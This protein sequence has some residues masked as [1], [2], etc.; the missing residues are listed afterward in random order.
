MGREF[1]TL[2]R[3]WRAFAPA[4]RAHVFCDDHAV[5]GSDFLVIEYR[6]GVVIWDSVPVSMAQHA[7]VAHRTGLAVV[8]ALA[9]L[10]RVDPAS[11]DL[12]DLGRPEGFV[13]R[14]VRGWSKRWELASL[15]DAEPVMVEVGEHL[16]GTLPTSRYVSI[17]HNDYKL[18]NCQ[19]DPTD[20][21]HVKSVFDWD[22][23]TLGDPF[24][25]LGITLNYWPDP[26]DPE[27]LRPI[28][29]PGLEHLGLPTRSEV[30][31]RYVER[32]GFDVDDVRWYEAFAAWK[33]AVVLQQ[34]Y[35]RWVRGESTDPRMAERGP[36][37]GKQAR[38]AA[39]IIDGTAP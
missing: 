17:L 7:D 1:R 16:A 23:A 22:M 19:F 15:D 32:T 26:A 27:D 33:T 35:A 25:D 24:I 12:S 31:S 9:D 34:L 4:P 21:D 29:S 13:E 3:L 14:Q 20:P 11:V 10:H 6:E 36:L 5:I 8:D 28:V 37:V 2:S 39:A 18:D 38:R 30:V